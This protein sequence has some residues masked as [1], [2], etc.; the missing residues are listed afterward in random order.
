[1]EKIADAA[2]AKA[3]S[4]AAVA[5]LPNMPDSPCPHKHA[6]PNPHIVAAVPPA[7]FD[8]LVLETGSYPIAP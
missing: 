3:E 2:P 6:P 5:S 7:A 8:I 1:M 4:R